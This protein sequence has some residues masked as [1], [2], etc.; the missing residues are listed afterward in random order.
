MRE[1]KRISAR[2]PAAAPGRKAS[3]RPK[4]DYSQE[5]MELAVEAANSRVL[6]DGSWALL[7]TEWFHLQ[8]SEAFLAKL[9]P[10][11]AADNVDRTNFE[12]V[13]LYV[14]GMNGATQAVVEFGYA[15]NGPSDKLYC[16]SRQ[17][18]CVRGNQTGSDYSFAFE[19]VTPVPCQGGCTIQ[20]PAIPGRVLYYRA[21]YL[22]DSGQTV[23]TGPAA[24]TVVP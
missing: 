24:A 2:G 21:R 7:W 18:T 4:H 12:Q 16:T 23:L 3:A 22:N 1:R 6:P 13:G 17:E 8:R 10:F 20:I 19:P 5:L 11:P 15:E 9:P 14:S